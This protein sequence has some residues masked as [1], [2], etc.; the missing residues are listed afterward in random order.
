VDGGVETVVGGHLASDLPDSFGRIELRRVRW[1]SVERDTV[2][3]GGQPNASRFVEPVAGPVVD[4]EEDFSSSVTTHEQL[5]K[6]VE[7]VAVEDRSELI[8]EARVVQTHRAEHVSGLSCA[9]GV[10][11]RLDAN[12]TPRL[13]ERAVEPEAGFVLEDNGTSTGGGFFLMAGNVVRSHAACRSRSARASRLRGRC[14]E[15]PS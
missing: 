13:V 14:T 15:K 1:E 10:Y 2:A 12:T 6:L 5:E 9:V 7:R 8:R 3:I 4:D 11:A